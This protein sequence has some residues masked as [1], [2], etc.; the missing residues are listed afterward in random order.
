MVILS[1][2]R[3]MRMA[4][5]PNNQNRIAVDRSEEYSCRSLEDVDQ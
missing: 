2:G 5:R 1:N 4:T 3:E